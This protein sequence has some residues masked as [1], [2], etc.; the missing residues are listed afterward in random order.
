MA[1]RSLLGGFTDLMF[2]GAASPGER[3]SKDNGLLATLMAFVP[4][5]DVPPAGQ[6]VPE[7][8]FAAND[9]E[10]SDAEP[11]RLERTSHLAHSDAGHD[12][13]PHPP[14]ARRRSHPDHHATDNPTAQNRPHLSAPTWPNRCH[15]PDGANHQRRRSVEPSRRVPASPW[16]RWPRWETS[17]AP[18][19]G[20]VADGRSRIAAGQAAG[21]PG[22]V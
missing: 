5:H 8:D 17:A 15:V 9:A 10:R 14:L 13:R 19:S 22:I 16:D 11:L 18:A 7:S 6:L 3:G 2:S 4:H 12:D 1:W 20:L 21:D